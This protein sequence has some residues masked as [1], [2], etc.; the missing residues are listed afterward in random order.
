[1]P[2]APRPRALSRLHLARSAHRAARLWN[3]VVRRLDRLPEFPRRAVRAGVVGELTFLG[4]EGSQLILLALWTDRDQQV[5]F[6]DL[7]RGRGIEDHLSV[8]ALDRDHD[9]SEGL[10]QAGVPQRLAAEAAA[11]V[12]LRLFDLQGHVVGAGREL[13]EVHYAG[14]QDRLGHAL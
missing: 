4:R 12:D 1:E 13:D 8:R 7:R 14:T 11:L 9:E 6:D 2:P 3:P 10:T 5:A